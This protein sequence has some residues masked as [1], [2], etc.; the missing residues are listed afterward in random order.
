MNSSYLLKKQN[1]HS[2]PDF[3]KENV[4]RLT[5][6]L[7]FPEEKS[8][9]QYEHEAWNIAFPFFCFWTNFTFS[10]NIIDYRIAHLNDVVKTQHDQTFNKPQPKDTNLTV[11]LGTHTFQTHDKF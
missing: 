8:A 2:F 1:H 4:K 7:K 6:L 3:S 10:T 9:R 5:F 11:F